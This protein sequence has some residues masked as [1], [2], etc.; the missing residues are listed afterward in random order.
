MVKKELNL[1]LLIEINDWAIQDLPKHNQKCIAYTQPDTYVQAKGT[2][3]W[4]LRND[5]IRFPANGPSG[6]SET[7]PAGSVRSI[8]EFLPAVP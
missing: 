7:R 5:A 8:S 4:P 2:E 6:D 1:D 3:F